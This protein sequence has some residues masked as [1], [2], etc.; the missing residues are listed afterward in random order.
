MTITNGYTTLQSIRERLLD[1]HSY[2]ADTLS[3][4]SA[5][6][7]I[8]DT[9]RGLRRFIEQTT[10]QISGSVDNDGFYTVTSGGSASNLIVEEALTDESAGETVTLID[11][12]DLIDDSAIESVI[13]AVSRWIDEHTGRKFYSSDETR[14]Y[15]AEHYDYL[16][17]DDLLS[18]TTLKTDTTGDG[19]Y[20]TTWTT[21]DYYLDPA[22]ADLESKPY[23]SIV[24][25]PD[26]NESFTTLRRGV[27]IV[28]AF[29]YSATTPP[30]ISEACILGSMRLL[31]RKDSIFGVTGSPDFGHVRAIL[32]QDPDI[33][34]LLWSFMRGAIYG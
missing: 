13:E 15:T 11:Q 14:V 24:L 5:T 28:G 10:I 26:G 23:T 22:N 32:S 25:T 16:S 17:I 34:N 2:T 1:Q 7:T 21:D 6:K 18:V 29:G 3:F 9:A 19:T 33:Y 30:P 12:S 20:D 31:K 4:D 8:T 27:Q